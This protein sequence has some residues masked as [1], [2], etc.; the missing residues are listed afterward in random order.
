MRA[1]ATRIGQYF[2]DGGYEIIPNVLSSLD[3]DDLTRLMS[4]I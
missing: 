1:S 2:E 4:G 3:P